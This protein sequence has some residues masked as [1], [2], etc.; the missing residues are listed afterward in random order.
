VSA[1]DGAR[2]A[3]ECARA[4]LPFEVDDERAWRDL[5]TR[6]SLFADGTLSL[7]ELEE[8]PA[9]TSFP[10]AFTDEATTTHQLAVASWVGALRGATDP[11]L[12]LG[13]LAV[14]ILA[15]AA[16][17]GMDARRTAREETI[18]SVEGFEREG[19]L[20]TLGAAVVVPP[21]ASPAF[22]HAASTVADAFLRRAADAIRVAIPNPFE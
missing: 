9:P 7:G 3:V 17:R 8:T 13:Q 11:S 1:R 14:A 12:A 6:A 21:S 4:L 15:T 5:V 2:A 22:D 18:A 10:G 16:L 20:K 19:R